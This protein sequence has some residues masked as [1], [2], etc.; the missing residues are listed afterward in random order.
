MSSIGTDEE[1]HEQAVEN[2]HRALDQDAN[3]VEQQARA[4]ARLM[5][6]DEELWQAQLPMLI[7]VE[8]GRLKAVWMKRQT[9]E[10]Q[11][12]YRAFLSSR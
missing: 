9:P 2:V 7:A 12:A 6:K 10:W 5:N 11:Q 1:R 8:E 4:V 3:E